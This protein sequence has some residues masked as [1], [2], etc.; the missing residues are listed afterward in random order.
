MCVQ[1]LQSLPV[2][3]KRCPKKGIHRAKFSWWFSQGEGWWPVILHRCKN[4]PIPAKTPPF[5]RKITAIVNIFQ[6]LPKN[7]VYLCRLTIQFYFMNAVLSSILCCNLQERSKHSCF[8]H[9]TECGEQSESVRQLIFHS[10]ANCTAQIVGHYPEESILPGCFIILHLRM[11]HLVPFPAFSGAV[12]SC[13]ELTLHY[14]QDSGP[15]FNSLVFTCSIWYFHKELEFLRRC[16]KTHLWVGGLW[17]L[18]LW[19]VLK[20]AKRKWFWLWVAFPLRID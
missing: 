14:C 12:F 6:Q 18:L 4:N 3:G 1:D 2:F 19:I 9:S 13:L 15:I 20:S 5:P 8:G 7:W 10:N 17:I 11:D 16:S